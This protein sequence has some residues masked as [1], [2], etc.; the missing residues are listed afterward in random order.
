MRDSLPPQ[1]GIL[2]R[3][4]LALAVN[5]V[6]SPFT[7]VS[8]TIRGAQKRRD[9]VLEA[10]ARELLRPIAPKLSHLIS[11]GWNPRLKTT[12]GVAIAARW[13]IWLNPA[14]KQIS[15]VEIDR[16]L[17]HELAHL[18]AQHRHGTRRISPHGTEWRQ[19]CRDLGIPDEGRTH[20]L[21]FENRRMKR[22]YRL[23]CPKCGLSHE[24]VRLPRGR[25]AC[26]SC[27][28]QH[29]GGRYHELF[30]LEVVKIG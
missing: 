13:E 3:K 30:R 10:R 23:H 12:A 16:T 2:F 29:L 25:V 11:V 4:I 18:I 22:R 19:A 15:E 5:R 9:S 1:M 21:P 14:L 8:P 27:C 26:L 6:N 28:R 24:R 7:P 20:Q 17:T